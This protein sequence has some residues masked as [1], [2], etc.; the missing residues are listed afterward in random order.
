LEEL[1]MD[2]KLTYVELEKRVE[3]LEQRVRERRRV[4]EALKESEER[5]EQVAENA[6]EWIWEVD[7][8]G[9]YTYASPPVSK[10]LGYNPEEIVGKK[11]FYDLFHP[12][13]REDLKK[14]AF[15][16]F[17]KQETF[18]E[19]VNRNV[20]KN[21]STVWL[22]TSGVPIVDKEGQLTGYRG[23]DTNVTGHV[24]VNEALR[25]SE[26]RYRSTVETSPDVIFK[27]SARDGAITSL[28]AAFRR[29]TG[30]PAEQW[31]GKSFTSIIH[32]DDLGVAKEK[33]RQVLDGDSTSP[34]DL[35]VYSRSGEELVGEFIAAPE[36]KDGKVTSVFGFARDITARVRAERAVR[37]S[38]EHLGS[39]LESATNFAV[40]RLVYDE[41][42]THRLRVVF[43]SPSICDIMGVSDPM[44]FE[45]WFKRTHPDLVERITESLHR[46]FQ[47]LKFDETIQIYHVK[48]QEWRWIQVIATG[49]PEKEG[50]AFYVNGILIDISERKRL[51]KELKIKTKNL[52][53]MNA[54][55]RVLLKRRDEDKAELE[56]KVVLNV[57]RLIEP[58]LQKLKKDVINKSLMNYLAILESNLNEII[59]PFSRRLSLNYSNLT[60]SELQVANLVKQ[61]K[62]TKEIAAALDLSSRTIDTH[63]LRIRTKLGIRNKKANLRSYLL[64]LP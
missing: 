46:I 58:Y 39:L 60:S 8:R 50:R 55:L 54:A 49:V 28:N 1:L 47:T 9:L 64:S 34:F 33:F 61:G 32:N 15:Y 7:S 30:W 14:A 56:E 17:S 21:G 13:D 16:M 20:H 12:E 29:I 53:E 23:V 40:Y 22:L 45:T 26:E 43:V 57:K 59:S 51:E 6:E 2:K 11:H 41:K 62:T 36:I 5:F 25:K 19:F 48:E 18:R 63:R 44:K 27:I 3:E 35:R 42:S 4:E 10:V 24:R 37:E 31:I 38:E 52:E